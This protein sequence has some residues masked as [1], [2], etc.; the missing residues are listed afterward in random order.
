MNMIFH[1]SN[2][3]RPAF[4]VVQNPAKVTVEFGS[5]PAIT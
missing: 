2:E 3:N 4:Y 1:S 5:Q